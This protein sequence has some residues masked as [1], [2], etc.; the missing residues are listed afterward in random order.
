MDNFFQKYQTSNLIL[1]SMSMDVLIFHLS[2]KTL[3]KD[4]H[5]PNLTIFAQPIQL[6]HNY[7]ILSCHAEC[8]SFN[9]LQ[10]RA[11][12]FPFL[13]MEDENTI[14]LGRFFLPGDTAS[15]GM[16]AQIWGN[17]N[18]SILGSAFVTPDS[19]RVPKGPSIMN[20][21][22]WESKTVKAPSKE[23]ANA[24]TV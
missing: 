23:N 15:R 19:A 10:F 5:V 18:T 12:I 11:H 21:I 22:K 2:Q 9:L 3:V 7:S 1:K 13:P 17:K 24:H 8:V 6:Q 20:C 16:A 14:T 4:L